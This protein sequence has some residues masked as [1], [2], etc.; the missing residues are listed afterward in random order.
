MPVKYVP[1]C[2]DIS[3]KKDSDGVCWWSGWWEACSRGF[4][5]LSWRK[6]ILATLSAAADRHVFL[7]MCHQ[8]WDDTDSPVSYKVVSPQVM[9]VGQEKKHITILYY[10]PWTQQSTLPHATK[11]NRMNLD[12]LS[13]FV[14]S[15]EVYQKPDGSMACLGRW[16]RVWKERD[17]WNYQD[18]VAVVAVWKQWAKI[19]ALVCQCRSHCRDELLSPPT[20]GRSPYNW[21]HPIVDP[22]K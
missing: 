10:L 9:L 4:L 13:T 17:G 20:S 18:V 6:H 12:H 21:S 2:P 1:F 3:N 22:W 14:R 19:L 8:Q 11:V 15:A 7:H 16:P 5:S